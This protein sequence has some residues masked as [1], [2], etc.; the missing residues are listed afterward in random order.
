MQIPFLGELFAVI[1]AFFYGL[2]AVAI[3]KN[4]EN[5]FT[6]NGAYLSV[7][8]TA[9]ISG[10]LWLIMGNPIPPAGSAFWRGIAGLRA[11]WTGQ[12]YFPKPG[13]YVLPAARFWRVHSCVTAVWT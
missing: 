3:V 4:A 5:G 7:V 10:G 12:P 2:S 6:N 11:R 9:A 13:W 1:S 8:L